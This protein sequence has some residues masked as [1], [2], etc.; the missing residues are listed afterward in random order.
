TEPM[1]TGENTEGLRKIIDLTRKASIGMLFL[2]CYYYCY[3]SF[4]KWGISHEISERLI[5]TVGDTGLFN[6]F[7]ISKVFALMLLLIS[8]IGAKGKKDDKLRI[9]QILWPL[10]SGFLIYAGSFFVFYLSFHEDT[11]SI[12]YLSATSF[13]FI[14][15]LR[16]GALLSRLL[17][18]R[19]D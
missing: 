1:Q 9:A 14:L 10:I 4:N 5:L 8:L 11:V 12:I 19:F 13:G 17:K 15:I 16:G 7:Y 3:H 2:H 18:N 6:E